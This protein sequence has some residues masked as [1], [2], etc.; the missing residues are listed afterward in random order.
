[1]GPT[2]YSYERVKQM[3]GVTKEVAGEIF[4]RDMEAVSARPGNVKPASFSVAHTPDEIKA[5][6][7]GRPRHDTSRPIT[8]EQD[9]E[10]R[11]WQ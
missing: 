5:D 10:L 1:M 2:R 7:D 6:F 9:R 8:E 4:S 11:D 3:W